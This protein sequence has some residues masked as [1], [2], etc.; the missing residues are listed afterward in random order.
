MINGQDPHGVVEYVRFGKTGLRVSRIGLGCMSFGSSKW[1]KWVLDK[2]ES[3]PVIKRA[4]DLGINFF[5]TADAYSNGES[6][7]VLGE[8]IRRYNIPREQIVIATKVFFPV[9]EDIGLNTLSRPMD[10]PKLVNRG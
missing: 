1:Q 5:D 6:E 8:A 3:L 2:D 7:V 4:F 9:S 10:D